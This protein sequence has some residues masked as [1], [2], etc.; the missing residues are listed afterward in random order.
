VRRQEEI[1]WVRAQSFDRIISLLGSPHNL[2]AYDES[3]LVWANYP[4]VHGVDPRGSL[5][6][7]YKDLEES[8]GGG[9]RVLVHHDELSD[10]VTGTV[11]G[12]LCWSH[13][14]ASPAQATWL[15]ERIVGRQMGSAGRELVVIARRVA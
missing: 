1:I 9:L 15:V 3:G 4:L 10:R 13:R 8:L 2:Q 7:C 11:A 12:F 6:D 5:A 14:A